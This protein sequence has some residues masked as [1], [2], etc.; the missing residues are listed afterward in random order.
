MNLTTSVR[1]KGL[2]L[3][4][5]LF[6]LLALTRITPNQL[7]FLSIVF[8]L[9]AAISFSRASLSWA[10]ALILLS[11]LSDLA[12]GAVAKRNKKATQF[13]AIFDWLADKYT[14]AILVT[15]VVLAGYTGPVWGML[16]IAGTLIHSFMKPTTYYELGKKDADL[17]KVGFFGRPETIITLLLFTLFGAPGL[18]VI[19]IAILSNMSVLQRIVYLY[20]VYK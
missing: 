15:G 3:L 20:V 19:L 14:D 1:K 7:S 5:P 9:F 11:A 4:S 6:D 8:A 18:G 12:D 13:G 16:A 10:A 2:S 17:E